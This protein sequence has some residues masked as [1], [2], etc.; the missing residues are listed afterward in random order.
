MYRLSL[1][2]IEIYNKYLPLAEKGNIR[3]NLDFSDTTKTVDEPEAIKADL[4][5]HLSSALSRS[6]R[7][8][9]SISVEQDAIVVT[10]SGT[11][12]SKPICALLSKGRVSVTSR[13]GFGTTARISLLP[14]PPEEKP[15]PA[16]AAKSSVSTKTPLESLPSSQPAK[17]PKPAKKSSTSAKPTREQRKL[18]TAAKK[19]DRKIQKL[20]KSQRKQ[21]A[22]TKPAKKTRKK[23]LEFS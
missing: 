18:I 11:I 10:D 22:K 5:K 2:I 12:L 16:P 23:V 8:E 21:A 7:G 14:P 20:R 15:L 1:V 13:V 4:E 9:I 3:L 6:D 19:A 17:H